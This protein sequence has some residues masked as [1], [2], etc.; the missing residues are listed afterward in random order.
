MPEKLPL[1]SP[2]RICMWM[3][4]GNLPLSVK[5]FKVHSLCEKYLRISTFYATITL[6]CLNL[7]CVIA[8]C[9]W[10]PK[11]FEYCGGNSN[12]IKQGIQIKKL[13]LTYRWISNSSSRWNERILWSMET[14]WKGEMEGAVCSCNSVGEKWISGQQNSSQQDSLEAIRTLLPNR[15]I[16]TSEVTTA[17]LIKFTQ[18]NSSYQMNLSCF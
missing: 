7:H 14:L 3:T 11:H 1:R 6:V 10:F 8:C 18:L 16:S 9:K 5:P 17:Y 2:L 15:R 13:K 12:L 4:Q